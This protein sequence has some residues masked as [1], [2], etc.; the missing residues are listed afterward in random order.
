[1]LTCASS[2]I[3]RS[4][5]PAAKTPAATQF[6]NPAKNS[7]LSKIISHGL[8]ASQLPEIYLSLSVQ[9]LWCLYTHYC[10]VLETSTNKRR[11]TEVPQALLLRV[12]FCSAPNDSAHSVSVTASVV[13]LQT[14]FESKRTSESDPHRGYH[15]HQERGTCRTYNQHAHPASVRTPRPEQRLFGHY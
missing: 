4:N 15:S 5:P 2:N 9:L 1:L 10:L 11:Q 7:F 12:A 3:D 14:N 13:D 8:K 6:D